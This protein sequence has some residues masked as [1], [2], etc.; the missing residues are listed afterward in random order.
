MRS[1]LSLSLD[2]KTIQMAKK[3]TKKYGFKSVS[4]YLRKVI[5]ENEELITEDEILQLGEEAQK[6]YKEGKTIKAN[7]IADLL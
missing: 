3:Q 1:V 4:E 5:T 7:S 6:E 2:S